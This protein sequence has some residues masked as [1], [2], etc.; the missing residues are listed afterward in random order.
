M[1]DKVL[2]PMKPP[3]LTTG[4]LLSSLLAVVA[5]AG[6]AQ[7]AD[8]VTVETRQ[9]TGAA[10]DRILV[11]P[12]AVGQVPAA[13]LST[14][15]G[16]SDKLLQGLRLDTTREAIPDAGIAADTTAAT[17]AGPDAGQAA[18]AA[19]AAKAGSGIAANVLTGNGM[20]LR[21]RASSLSKDAAL[22]EGASAVYVDAAGNPRALPGGVIVTF[23]EALD[24]DAARAAIEASGHQVLRE[25]GPRMWLVDSAAGEATLETAR[26]LASDTQFESVEP[27]WWRPP[28]RK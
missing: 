6:V 3:L 2:R 20:L 8:G 7:A 21:A 23:R 14:R 15:A 28:V 12:H 5:P 17:A 10:G 13:T 11:K 19:Q 24:A 26:S 16:A 4:L 22:G 1:V 9:T 18:Q 27:N 25:V